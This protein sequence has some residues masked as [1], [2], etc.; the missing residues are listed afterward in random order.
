M[1][2]AVDE[3]SSPMRSFLDTMPLALALFGLLLVQQDDPWQPHDPQHRQ[4][5][6][7]W[8][9]A[10]DAI[11]P[12]HVCSCH[13]ECKENGGDPS[14]DGDVVEDPQCAVYCHPKSCLCPIHGCP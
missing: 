3:E 13:R 2:R 14:E 7:G 9:C 8:T 12:A 4:P 10:H 11:D 6:P 1:D 5:P